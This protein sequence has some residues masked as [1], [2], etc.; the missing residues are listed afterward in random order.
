[1]PDQMD[2]I[3]PKLT[4]QVIR[5]RDKA[6]LEGAMATAA[7]VALADSQLVIEE[8]LAVQAV[9]ENAKALELY[10]PELATSMFTR[11]VDALRADF[12]SGKAA[13]LRIISL[14]DEDIDAVALILQVGVAVAKADSQLTGSERDVI[15]DICASLGVT[16]LDATGLIGSTASRAH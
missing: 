9:L 11:H 7:L 6:L 12:E 16:G 4:R 13:A 5:L 3:G 15:E 10:D 14:C 1:M 2:R 8:S